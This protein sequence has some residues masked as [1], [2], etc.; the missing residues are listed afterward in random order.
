MSAITGLLSS[1][2]SQNAAISLVASDLADHEAEATIHFTEASI[3]HAN[4]LNIGTKAHTVIDTHI[5]DTTIHFTMADVVTAGDSEWLRLDCVND[6]LTETLE[7]QALLPVGNKSRDIG[8]FSLHYRDVF[9]RRGHFIDA[10]AGVSISS[11]GSEFGLKLAGNYGTQTL[12]NSGGVVVGGSTFINSAYYPPT[13]LIRAKNRNAVIN[14]VALAFGYLAEAPNI[15]IG[16]EGAGNTCFP[17]VQSIG[18]GGTLVIKAGHAPNEVGTLGS[19][20]FG[21]IRNLSGNLGSTTVQIKAFSQACLVQGGVEI[22]A[23]TGPVELSAYGAGAMARGLIKK[24]NI[25]AAQQACFSSGFSDTEL[26]HI[27]T[28]GNASVAIGLVR[29]NDGRIEAMEES[30]F[31]FGLADNVT[32]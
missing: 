14:P 15:E 22:N 28:D 24:G 5:D 17:Y 10:A 18:G 7:T 29:G 4:I 6:P 12:S 19:V 31:A 27:W 20:V 21:Y 25:W 2:S 26:G 23:A 13:L 1:Q 9:A 3:D 11:T 16:A 32:I 8:S 30:T